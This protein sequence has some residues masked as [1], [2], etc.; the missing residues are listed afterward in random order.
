MC[1]NSKKLKRR[2]RA[3]CW[4]LTLNNYTDEHLSQLSQEI[5]FGET[6]QIKYIC[7]EEIGESGTKHLQGVVQYENQVDFSK[8]RKLHPTAHWEICKN[9]HSCLKYCGKL[10]TRN[11]EVFQYGDVNKY[12]EQVPKSLE[13]L[14]EVWRRGNLTPPSKY[15][16]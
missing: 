12:V 13:E 10:K 7:Q 16:L 5:F 11:G 4:I 14:M 9:L 2:N 6:R 8:L 15:V 1:D 3:R